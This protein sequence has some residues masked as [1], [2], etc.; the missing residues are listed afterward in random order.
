MCI[1]PEKYYRIDKCNRQIWKHDNEYLSPE[2]KDLIWI[3]SSWHKSKS[4]SLSV[5]HLPSKCSSADAN[6]PDS[7]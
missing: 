3:S 7:I 6:S 2:T 5:V 4:N 1:I